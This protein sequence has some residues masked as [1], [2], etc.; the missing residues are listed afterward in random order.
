MR[1][2]IDHRTEAIPTLVL[3][4]S[5]CA[6]AGDLTSAEEVLRQAAAA[7][8][9]EV[10]LLAA[11][12]NVLQRRGL[13]KSAD[14]LG[15]YRAAYSR[16]RHQGLALSWAL[17]RAGKPV[18]AEEL[19]RE[20]VRQPPYDR[21]AGAPFYLGTALVDQKRYGEAEAALR[22]S[23]RL[24]PE[25]APAYSNLGLALAMQKQYG[26]A[27]AACR[28]AV[29]IDLELAVAYINLAFVLDQQGQHEQ[30]EAACRQAL[31]LSPRA[32]NAWNNLGAALYDQGKHG[33]A[34]AAFRKAIDVEPGHFQARYNLG[35]AL[36]A[37]SR[38]REAEAAFRQAIALQP[39]DADAHNN[40]GASLLDQKK[41]GAA[42]AAFRQAIA[43]HPGSGLA[44]RNLGYTLLHQARFD[45]AAAALRK[46]G[47]LLPANSP[48]R[49]H[50]RQLEQQCERYKVLDA[51]FAAILRGKEQPA[52]ALEQLLFS[53]LCFTKKHYAGAARFSL[54]AFAAEP[55]LAD[56]LEGPRYEAAGAAALAG[57]GHGEDAAEL[58]DKERARWRRQALAWLRQ[59]LASWDRVQRANAKA[60]VRVRQVMQ[61]WQADD[62]LAG[63]RD[64]DA[65][66]RLP[67]AERQECR[68][69]WQEVEALLRR[70]QTT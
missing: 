59:D 47:D 7:R 33:E 52:D 12:A 35:S 61:S 56:G 11:L 65:L 50:A 44:Y 36:V 58:D 15:Y 66:E 39:E 18:E 6:D 20:L 10:L 3:Y 70:A 5:A 60:G 21:D 9:Q 22:E 69:L 34:E 26:P 67:P 1:A 43:L 23:L 51:R 4:A 32:A 49:Q 41:Y 48:V 68:A 31:A 45:E 54:A 25:W 38:H 28:Q 63:L 8:P 64:A 14:A 24:R 27:E 17:L 19:L 46:V 55:K 62:D 53:Q 13:S 29:A 42:E 2:E 37:Q 30:A 40:L 16:S 57:C